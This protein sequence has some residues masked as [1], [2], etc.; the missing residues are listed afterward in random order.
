[1][2][3]P[4]IITPDS[5]FL[6]DESRP[7]TCVPIHDSVFQ[8]VQKAGK[9]GAKRPASPTFSESGR[10]TNRQYVLV[11]FAP[12]SSSARGC[13]LHWSIPESTLFQLYEGSH[14]LDVKLTTGYVQPFQPTWNS[15]IAGNP[16]KLGPGVFGT[17][18]AEP[19]A[20]AVVNTTQYSEGLVFVFK[21]ADWVEQAGGA[22]ALNFTCRAIGDPSVPTGPYVRYI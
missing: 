20:N 6:L 13:E 19:G 1:M 22:A 7:D 4:N 15:L 11:H 8:V 12:P 18:N 2:S 14:Q 16:P 9:N 10:A 21:F 17:V 3:N 5:L